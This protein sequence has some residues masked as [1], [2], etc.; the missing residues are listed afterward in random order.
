M[1]RAARA[2]A[3]ALGLA[4][5][6]VAAGPAEA[7]DWTVGR[8]TGQ[9]WITVPGTPPRAATPGMKLPSG[10]TLS[11]AQNGRVRLEGS[12]GSLQIGPGTV[13]TARQSWF[14]ASTI[15]QQVGQVEVEVERG[16]RGLTIE[17]PFL[18]TT[19]SGARLTIDV[20]RRDAS[21]QVRSGRADVTPNGTWQSRDLGTGQRATAAAGGGGLQISRGDAAPPGAE[22]SGPGQGRAGAGGEVPGRAGGA[23][24]ARGP[25]GPGSNARGADGRAS[26]GSDGRGDRGGNGGGRGGP[27]GGSDKGGADG[28]GGGR[29]GDRGGDRGGGDKGGNGK[30]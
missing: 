13:V 12:T 8:I 19:V 23:A 30:D 1:T 4:L 10:Q 6:L 17:T 26:E 22:G 14:G 11:T 18:S 15:V 29:G 21:V 20:S 3:Q 5:A 2:L 9:A 24:A 7:A 27:E 28:P 16:R 25:E